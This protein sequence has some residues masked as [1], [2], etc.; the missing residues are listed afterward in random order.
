MMSMHKIYVRRSTKHLAMVM[1][2]LVSL[3][4]VVLCTASSEYSYTNW[5]GN[6]DFKAP[7]YYEPRSIAEVQDIVKR[8]SRV[9]VIGTRFG[10]NNQLETS[11]ALISFVHLSSRVSCCTGGIGVFEGGATFY[12]VSETINARSWALDS[13]PDTADRSFIGAAFSGGHGSGLIVQNF[14]SLFESITFVTADGSLLKIEKNDPRMQLASMSL[15][16]LGVVVEFAIYLRPSYSLRQCVYTS[17][18]MSPALLS[19]SG[20]ANAQNNFD[21]IFNSA[22]SVSAF[23]LFKDAART[24]D[25]RIDSQADD[26]NLVFSSIW[27]KRPADSIGCKPNFLSTSWGGTLSTNNYDMTTKVSAIP[28]MDPTYSTPPHIAPWH[29]ILP[30]FKAKTPS[31]NVHP[32]YRA[33]VGAGMD[34]LHSEYFLPRRKASAA[35]TALADRSV[36]SIISLL[37]AVCE[38]QVVAPDNALLSPCYSAGVPP[39][40]ALLPPSTTVPASVSVPS[41]Y[42]CV[43]LQFVWRKSKGAEPIKEAISKVEEVL[44]PLGARPHWGKIF[45]YTKEEVALMYVETNGL[46]RLADLARSVDPTGKF[47]APFLDTYVFQG[48]DSWEKP[49]IKDEL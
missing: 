30:H 43:S 32:P 17:V 15:G 11:G 36:R 48:V 49:V 1:L 47:R 14:A 9:R 19:G 40:A 45:T 46:K 4:V 16:T 18:P 34:E 5:A 28:G 22:Y 33:S 25:A 35:L 29:H 13:M 12:E 41:D 42:G 31:F 8:H 10:M 20:G 21:S 39:P 38:I 37:L 6:V 3:L 24:A 23:T 27:L 7:N 2:S 44:K 26:G